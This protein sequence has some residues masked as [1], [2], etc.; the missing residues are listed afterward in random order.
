MSVNHLAPS[1]PA[2]TSRT[3]LP[4]FVAVAAVWIGGMLALF[5]R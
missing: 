1:R 3:A 4:L 5:Q 2:G